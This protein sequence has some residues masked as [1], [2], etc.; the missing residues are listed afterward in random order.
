MSPTATAMHDD[1]RRAGYG[2][3]HQ[4]MLVREQDSQHSGLGCCGR[5]HIR[6]SA[7]PPIS[8]TAAP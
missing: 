6:C 7:K 3:G 1:E 5:E 2:A 8:A 4:L